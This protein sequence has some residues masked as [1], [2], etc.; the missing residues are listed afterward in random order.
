MGLKADTTPCLTRRKN[1]L[2]LCTRT[3]FRRQQEEGWL[4]GRAP[5]SVRLVAAF[6]RERTLVLSIPAGSRTL[7]EIG[8]RIH[9]A[10]DKKTTKRTGTRSER[11]HD[12]VEERVNE[13]CVYSTHDL[14]SDEA[15]LKADVLNSTCHIEK[16][17]M[18]THTKYL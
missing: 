5:L 16:L 9:A 18:C 2:N 1:A 15:C 4:T 10:V 13:T 7:R 6:E 14:A 8:A 12:Q 17:V 3:P 11:F